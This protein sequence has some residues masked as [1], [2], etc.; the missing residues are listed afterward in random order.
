LAEEGA[1]AIF[2][3]ATRLELGIL[4]LLAA[5]ALAALISP[6]L[7]W[8]ATS[9]SFTVLACFLLGINSHLLLLK[10]QLIPHIAIEIILPD[11]IEENLADLATVHQ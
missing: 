7:I 2:T 4:R 3:E 6:E 1:V 9:A 10:D 8:F 5:I 11:I